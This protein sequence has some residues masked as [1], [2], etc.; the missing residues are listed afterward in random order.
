MKRKKLPTFKS[1]QEEQE[2]W[3][4]RDSA[5]YLDWS[6]AQIG[7]WP[8]LKPSLKTISIRLPENLIEALKF[9]AN[10]AD[11]PYQSLMKVFLAE[12]VRAEAAALGE[13]KRGTKRP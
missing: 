3:D 12:R 1:V 9:L 13:R 5:E 2:F 8:N 4:S 10:K 11:V 6:A 7:F